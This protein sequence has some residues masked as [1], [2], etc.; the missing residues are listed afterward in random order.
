MIAPGASVVSSFSSYWEDK[1]IYYYTSRRYLDSPMMF[2][3]T[4]EGDDRPYYWIH[5]VGTSQS[6]PV[7]AGIIALWMEA[8]PTLTVNEIRSILQRTSRFDEACM[9]APGGL[10]QAGFGKIDA[11]AGLLEVL[12]MA[13]IEE[14]PT[15]SERSHG[16][17]K[18]PPCFDLQGRRL[19]SQSSRPGFYIADGKIRALRTP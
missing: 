7:V 3:V 11:L 10:V 15:D 13:G 14:L 8:C 5:S 17:S 1:I 12:S 18:I 19:P 2:V 16:T 9:R 4:P 6:S